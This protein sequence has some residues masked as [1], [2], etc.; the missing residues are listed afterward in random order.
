MGSS[1]TKFVNGKQVSKKTPAPA[2]TKKTEAKPAAEK[3]TKVTVL[4]ESPFSMARAALLAGETDAQ[5]IF[6]KVL[7][8]F[9]NATKYC[10]WSTR[11]ALIK[12]EKIPA[13]VKTPKAPKVVKPA[14]PKSLSAIATAATKKAG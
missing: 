6:E 8:K 14:A 2:V 12:A 10:V 1:A 13:L 5:K 3:K 7:V 9:P 11:T 4:R